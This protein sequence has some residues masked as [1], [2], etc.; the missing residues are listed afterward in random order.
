MLHYLL[1]SQSSI[2]PAKIWCSVHQYDCGANI[3]AATR[4]S[5]M[6]EQ[7]HMSTMWLESRLSDAEAYRI[8][9]ERNRTF[10]TI[11]NASTGLT[12]LTLLIRLNWSAIGR[13][14]LDHLGDVVLVHCLWPSD[15]CFA[16][17][18]ARESERI[19]SQN[20]N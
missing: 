19:F 13:T 17:F 14:S 20:I 8:A 5:C 6:Y 7:G 11:E 16:V 10:G 2:F 3:D 18:L 12:Q 4:D 9:V 15:K 1:P